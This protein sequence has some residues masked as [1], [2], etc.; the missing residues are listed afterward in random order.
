LKKNV[1]LLPRIW[2]INPIKKA[3]ISQSKH[4]LFNKLGEYPNGTIET[5]M[6]K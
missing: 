2:Q 5:R 3:H 4:F 1:K 6:M